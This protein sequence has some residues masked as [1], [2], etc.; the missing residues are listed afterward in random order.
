MISN[1][2]LG[3]I[4]DWRCKKECSHPC[5]VDLLALLE[6]YRHRHNR[7]IFTALDGT[8][9]CVNPR[10]PPS[11]DRFYSSIFLRTIHCSRTPTQSRTVTFLVHLRYKYYILFI[12]HLQWSK[13]LKF[14]REWI[15]FGRPAQ[16]RVE[17]EMTTIPGHILRKWGVLTSQFLCSSCWQRRAVVVNTFP[18]SD[19]IKVRLCFCLLYTSR[20]V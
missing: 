8:P 17:D 10:N 16:I 5:R 3:I 18:A 13:K 15:G 14:T 7:C 20:C 1:L 12:N 2:I 9:F 4:R 11:W 19:V 6:P